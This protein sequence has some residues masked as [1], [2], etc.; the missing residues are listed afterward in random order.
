MAGPLWE[1]LFPAEAGTDFFMHVHA[2]FFPPG[3]LRRR[4][5][6]KLK[7]TLAF[8]FDQELQEVACLENSS[9][10]SGREGLRLLRGLVWS[11]PLREKKEGSG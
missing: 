10:R 8:L 4:G 7:D 1:R 11:A 9:G 3:P 6:V 5:P 2:A